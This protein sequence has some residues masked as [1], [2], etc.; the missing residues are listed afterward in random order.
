MRFEDIVRLHEE[1]IALKLR[2][3]ISQ[4]DYEKSLLP[5][6]SD[7]ESFLMGQRGC[8]TEIF[9]TYSENK[10]AIDSYVRVLRALKIDSWKEKKKQ[11][12]EWCDFIWETNDILDTS[13]EKSNQKVE[14]KP[15]TPPPKTK[16]ETK[17]YTPPPK[18]KVETKPYTPP[19]KT[20][21]KNKNDRKEPSVIAET[22]L[23]IGNILL[24]AVIA[25]IMFFPMMLWIMLK[26]IV[27]GP[28]ET[29]REVD[30]N[31]RTLQREGAYER[32]KRASN[33]REYDSAKQDYERYDRDY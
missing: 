28:D 2:L 32:M 21:A 20:N 24:Q 12:T 17:S 30:R 18:T 1:K 6:I 16:V 7:M 23:Y 8:V 25:G 14:T 29:T 11:V 3:Q 13:Q 10:T 27:S 4:E 26:S 31:I 9:N 22:G 33:Q 5:Y 19:P 15:Y